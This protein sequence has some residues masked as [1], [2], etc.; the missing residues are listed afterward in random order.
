VFLPRAFHVVRSHIGTALLLLAAVY[1][2]AFIYKTSFVVN[3]ERYF[4]LQD[5][6]MISMQ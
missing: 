6:S 2:A 1:Y 4:C 3:G 5:D